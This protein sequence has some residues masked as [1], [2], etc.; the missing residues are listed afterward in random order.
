M[1]SG[2]KT[3]I[4]AAEERSTRLISPR[5]AEP[6]IKPRTA[7]TRTVTG[8][9]LTKASSHTGMV[10]GSTKMLL[11]KV[12]GNRIIMLTPIT[13]FG[14]RRTSPSAVQIHEMLNANTLEKGL[15]VGG[16]T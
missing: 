11:A 9:T 1:V 6:W 7:D 16:R 12:R 3:A 8:F 10:C 4:K 2:A 14:V 13:E 5:V 15:I